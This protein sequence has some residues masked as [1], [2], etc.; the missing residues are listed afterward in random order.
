MLY[1]AKSFYEWIKTN[2][3]K[4]EFQEITR[5]VAVAIKN[6]QISPYMSITLLNVNNYV[7]QAMKNLLNINT[8]LA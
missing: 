8:N 6:N 7:N 2:E 4:P 1:F 5:D 3:N